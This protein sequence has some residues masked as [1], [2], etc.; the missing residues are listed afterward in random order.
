[1][2]NHLKFIISG[3]AL[4]AALIMFFVD[5]QSGTGGASR[6]VALF[7][8]VFAVFAIWVFPEAQAKE[9]RKEAAQRR[10]KDESST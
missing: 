10:A 5:T 9:I 4:G 7:L 8:G 1:M 3:L 2:P 6:W